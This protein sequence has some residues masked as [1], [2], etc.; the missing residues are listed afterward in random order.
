L[1][2]P[3]QSR[4]DRALLRLFGIVEPTRTY[5]LAIDWLILLRIWATLHVLHSAAM[6]MARWQPPPRCTMLHMV[7]VT[8]L[9]FMIT[10]GS[11]ADQLLAVLIGTER[12]DLEQQRN[13][14]V[15]QSADSY[16]KRKQTEDEILAVLSASRADILDD[17]GA[18]SAITEAQST[19]ND[20]SEKQA[21]DAVAEEEVDAARATC[22]P[23]L[24][25]ASNPC[26]S[27]RCRAPCPCQQHGVSVSIVLRESCSRGHIPCCRF[28]PCGV[29]TSL[30]FVTISD[31]AAL[32]PMYQYSLPWFTNLLVSSIKATAPAA[33]SVAERV[34][35]IQEHFT[36]TLYC[37]VCRS[38]FEQ[39]KLLF[40]FLLCSRVRKSAAAVDGEEWSFLL[41]GCAGAVANAP[42]PAPDWLEDRAW[43]DLTKLAGLPRFAGIADAVATDPARWRIVYDST[44]P[45]QETLPGHYRALDSFQK[46]LVTRC[47]RLDK[48]I[49]A[50]QDFIGEHLGKSFVEPPVF[51]LQASYCDSTSTVPL[52]FVTSPAFDPTAALLQFA[53]DQEMAGRLT[54]VSLGV[55]PIPPLEM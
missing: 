32:D 50:V 9:N 14:L 16:R 8:L 46:L 27:L 43:R 23:P 49:P 40:A 45:H 41:T 10:P 6:S 20:I 28:E 33:G 53:L 51:S 44:T 15:V 54:T 18:V 52:I 11:L 13:R 24:A 5:Q 30:L 7:Q 17:E 19:R 29:Y 4:A 38:L 21:L 12:P 42:N 35:A 39:D 25:T 47:L 36:S 1:E 2:H 26:V 37:K 3:R 55:A 48:V 34:V 22:V 31:L